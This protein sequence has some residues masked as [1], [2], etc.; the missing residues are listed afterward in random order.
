MKNEKAKERTKFY[1]MK[2]LIIIPAYNEAENIE[3]VVK[4][5][6]AVVSDMDY[7]IV[8]DCS[9]DNTIKVCEEKGYNYLSL[10]INLGIGGGVQMGYKY[11]ME[12]GYDIA[13]QHDGDG[14]HDPAYIEKVIK[15]IVDGEADIAI[16]SRFIDKAG[17]QSSG[18]RRMGI[19]FL[20]RLIKFC[21]GT[22]VLDVTS[23]FRAVNRK[24]IEYYAENY[25][26]DY[27]EPEAIVEASLNGARIVEI[28]VVM[29]ERENGV[30]SINAWRSIY[31]M[32]KVSCAIL[33]C[34]ITNR[35]K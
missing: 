26:T 25:P 27:P 9:K 4:Q 12:Q 33:V 16:G 21:C 3:N 19:R 29:K 20:S 24:Y 7:I 5:L 6:R 28:P 1:N 34:R 17:F 35:R 11:A 13:V 2:V 15:P 8:N 32:I 30:S 18:I 22:E 23:G 10:P 14:Q 31:Y